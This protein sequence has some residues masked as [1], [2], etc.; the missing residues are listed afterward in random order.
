M[1]EVGYLQRSIRSSLPQRENGF[2]LYVQRS[3]KEALAESSVGKETHE[4]VTVDDIGNECSY[5]SNFKPYISNNRLLDK[6]TIERVV[7][8]SKGNLKIDDTPVVKGRPHPSLQWATDKKVNSL[9]IK[10]GFSTYSEPTIGGM[11]ESLQKAAKKA[12]KRK[13]SWSREQELKEA[14]A[15]VKRMKATGLLKERASNMDDIFE[16]NVKV[17]TSKRLAG[18][19]TYKELLFKMAD[20]R[21]AHASPLIKTVEDCFGLEWTIWKRWRNRLTTDYPK[22][23]V[24]AMRN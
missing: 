10:I 5:G 19:M 18:F 16:K 8:E 22:G 4:C 24:A 23:D 6:E 9:P 11:K 3:E 1:G 21:N 14:R 13:V 17:Q 20:K 15:T 12:R 2:N 7:A